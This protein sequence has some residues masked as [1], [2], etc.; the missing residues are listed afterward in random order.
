[1]PR[2][3]FRVEVQPDYLPEQ[4]APE[5]GVFSFS[6]TITITN[7]GEVAAQLISR[8][9]VITDAAGQVQ[10]VKGL[11]VV[12]HQPLLQPGQSFQYTSGCRLRTPTGSMQGSYFCVAEDGERFD[13][14][15]APFLLDDGAKRVLH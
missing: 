8:H 6:Y 3:E 9:W 5:Q 4:S 12:G 2:Y 11:G 10:E 14:E 7:T 13:T 1:M 15:I